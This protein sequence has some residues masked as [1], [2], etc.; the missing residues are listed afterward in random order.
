M[1]VCD[2]QQWSLGHMTWLLLKK[3]FRFRYLKYHN[4]TSA[5]YLCFLIL[6]SQHEEILELPEAQMKPAVCVCAVRIMEAGAHQGSEASEEG[7]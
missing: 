1:H 7:L 6:E 2:V 4:S 3:L 5:A